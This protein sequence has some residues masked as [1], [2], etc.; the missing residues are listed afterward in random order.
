MKKYILVW[1]N[2]TKVI[3]TT[4][5]LSCGEMIFVNGHEATVVAV[6]RPQ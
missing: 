6:M 3:C 4:L 5:L 2:A 1:Q